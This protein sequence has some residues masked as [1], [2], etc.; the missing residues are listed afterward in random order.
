M[1]PERTVSESNMRESWFARHKRR[2]A[3]RRAAYFEVRSRR[4]LLPG[5]PVQVEITRIAAR[6]LD[7]DNLSG[8]AKAIRDGI[9][10]ALG[11]NDADP[12]V[13]WRYGQRGGGPG[14]CG[15]EIRIARAVPQRG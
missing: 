7:D 12:G 15:V 9:A 8:S 3:Q 2:A 10:D 14:Q 5:L 1:M 6:R 4:E 11:V 13:A